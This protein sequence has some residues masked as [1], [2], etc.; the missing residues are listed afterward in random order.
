MA[1]QHVIQ[2]ISGEGLAQ[3][4]YVA[5]RGGVEPATFRTEGTEH[6]HSANHDNGPIPYAAKSPTFRLD[7]THPASSPTYNSRARPGSEVNSCHSNHLRIEK[8]SSIF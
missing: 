3:G 6:H 8:K 7:S 4:P 5:A 1:P 2:A